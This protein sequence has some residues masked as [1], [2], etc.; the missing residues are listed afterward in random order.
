[1]A[2]DERYWEG[3]ELLAQQRP[4]GVYMLGYAAE[5]CLKLAVFRLIG[6]LNSEAMKAKLGPAKKLA[7]RY[8][9]HANPEGY[10]SLEF[11]TLLLLAS[12]SAR[13]QPFQP[14]FAQEL[15]IRGARLHLNWSVNLRYH[16]FTASAREMHEVLDDVDWIRAA[17]ANL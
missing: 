11:W 8:G 3:V 13:G 2:A 1:M 12:R 15:A 14:A 5:I 4:G 9:V 17:S 7:N 6:S 10:H 16:P